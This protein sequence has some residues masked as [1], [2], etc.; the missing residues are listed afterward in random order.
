VKYLFRFEIKGIQSFIFSSNKLK[1]IAGGS[2]IVDNLFHEK[3]FEQFGVD[4][5]WVKQCA[6]GSATIVFPSKDHLAAFVED[7]PMYVDSVAPGTELVYAWLPYEETVADFDPQLDALKVKLGENRNKRIVQLPELNPFIARSGQTGGGLM[8]SFQSIGQLDR[9]TKLKYEA[10]RNHRSELEETLLDEE[11]RSLYKLD[12]DGKQLE[13][14]DS[15][16][17][18]IHIDGND[19]GLRVSQCKSL[20]AYER[21]SQTLTTITKEAAKYAINQVADSIQ[22]LVSDEVLA[23]SPVLPIRPILVGGDDVT[24]MMD[25]KFALQFVQDYVIKFRELSS[26]PSHVEALFGSMEA[27]A[28]VAFVK[29]KSPFAANYHLSEALCSYAKNILRSRGTITSPKGELQNVTPSAV[30]FHRVTTTAYPD[31]D[32]TILPTELTVKDVHSEVVKRLTASPYLLG[33]Q[34]IDGFYK[35]SDLFAL[36]DAFVS[37]GEEVSLPRGPFR[38]WARVVQKDTA[39]AK[40][41]WSRIQTICREK[42]N[43]KF[44]LFENLVGEN[45]VSGFVQRNQG[46]NR[47]EV[48]SASVTPVLD[49]LVLKTIN[50]VERVAAESS[51]ASE[52]SE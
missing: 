4:G 42:Y 46:K 13:Q 36:S 45:N 28:G 2:A 3:N 48:A 51:I 38:E 44:A 7:F 32:G 9:S 50:N 26:S 20:R 16:I 8:H 39:L 18:V 35:L 52:V 21:F 34:S 23:Y 29:P 12:V 47:G 24:M 27:S 11:W 40:R 17:A 33:E 31:W 49:A 15:T 41:R 10:G 5:S 30:A 14:S 37:R 19:I 25:A 1:E 6:A 22:R 43:Q